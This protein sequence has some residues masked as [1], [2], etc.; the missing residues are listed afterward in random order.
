MKALILTNGDYGDYSFCQEVSSYDF[1]IC[2]DNG[3]KHARKLGILPHLIVGDFDSCNPEDISYFKDKGISFLEL[4]TQKDQTDTEVAMET[5]LQKGARVIDVYGG[6]GSRMDH[7]LANIQLVY[8]CLQKDVDMT[9]YNSQNIIQMTKQKINLKGEPGALVS[10]IPFTNAVTG[11]TTSGLAYPLEKSSFVLGD[12]LGVSNYMVG[13]DASVTIES[14]VL[15][16]I[17]SKD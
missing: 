2:A 15:V 17:Q 3:M 14:G 12:A 16:V 11:V 4:P 13:Q 10:L 8:R 5:A 1:I 7:S 9:L 6:V